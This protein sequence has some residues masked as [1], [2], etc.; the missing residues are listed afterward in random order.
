MKTDRMTISESKQ[1]TYVILYYKDDAM[2]YATLATLMFSKIKIHKHRTIHSLSV[3]CFESDEPLI[4]I[5][6]FKTSDLTSRR[7]QVT[8]IE[9]F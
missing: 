6:H 5:K 7:A 9:K 2:T 8:N 4:S 3:K 1:S